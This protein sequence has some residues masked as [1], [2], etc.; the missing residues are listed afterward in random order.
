[1]IDPVDV[2]IPAR[3][4]EKTIG[5]IC[6]ILST[7]LL[8]KSIIVVCD[9]CKDDT[10]LEAWKHGADIVLSREYNSKGQTVMAGL[11]HVV[12]D[13]VLFMDA[14]LSRLTHMHVTDILDGPTGPHSTM[15]I[16]VPDLDPGLPYT[17]DWAWPWVSGQRVVPTSLVK[18]LKLHGYL[19][20]TQINA[21]A[22]K[23]KL[24]VSFA[25]LTGLKSS[26]NMTERRL[27]EM[28]R[29]LQY[30]KQN[31]ILL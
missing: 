6:N 5:N 17:R 27:E 3:N 12:T 13:R 30:G 25:W 15:R 28:T 16:G 9:S 1:M 23:A 8:V 14:D 24:P 19:M 10:D 18:S 4:E 7:H 21:A 2:V 11:A 31:G 26:Y 20:E 22:S 29:D